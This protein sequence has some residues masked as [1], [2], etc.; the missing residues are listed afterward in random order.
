[1][2]ILDR[3][4]IREKRMSLPFRDR[5]VTVHRNQVLVW[6]SVHLAGA[7]E[8]RRTSRG[9]QRFSTAETTSTSQCR[10]GNCV[11]G[12]GS[13]RVCLRTSGTSR[14]MEKS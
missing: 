6:L 4:P 11:S 10:T 9:S 8:P 12:P 3:L 1:M 14:S 13:T 7:L 2:K 5:Y